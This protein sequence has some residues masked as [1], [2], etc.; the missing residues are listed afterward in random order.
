MPGSVKTDLQ[1]T[2]IIFPSTSGFTS[3]VIIGLKKKDPSTH[4]V[5]YRMVVDFRKSNEQLEY[6][7]FPLMRIQRIFSKLHGTNVCST[8]D[9]RFS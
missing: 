3:S 8:L 9:V 5:T 7:P 4:E 2:G 6:W 1:K